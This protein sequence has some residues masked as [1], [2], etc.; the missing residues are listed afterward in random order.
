MTTPVRRARGWG[1]RGLNA[2]KVPDPWGLRSGFDSLRAHFFAW[3]LVAPIRQGRLEGGSAS[4]RPVRCPRGLSRPA[5]TT[6]ARPTRCLHR[7]SDGLT[8]AALGYLQRRHHAKNRKRGRRVPHARGH[9]GEPQARIPRKPSIEVRVPRTRPAAMT[10]ART[11]RTEAGPPARQ[12]LRIGGRFEVDR[13]PPCARH[14]CSPTDS[15]FDARMRRRNFAPD[16]MA[17][18]ANTPKGKL[19]SPSTSARFA[20]RSLIRS[21]RHQKLPSASNR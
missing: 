17:N 6:P 10:A 19:S 7:D 16:Q 3:A 13:E 9:R 15:P 5:A 18:G 11:Y 4:D 2:P 21:G 8:A 14:G 1:P 12:H 20:Q